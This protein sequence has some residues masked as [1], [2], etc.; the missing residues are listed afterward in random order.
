MKSSFDGRSFRRYS[1]RETG[2]FSGGG[3][4]VEDRYG[5]WI[6]NM[7][8][9]VSLFRNNKWRYWTFPA[10]WRLAIEPSTDEI[11]LIQ[12]DGGLFR[13]DTSTMDWLK[14]GQAPSVSENCAYSYFYL[15][16]QKLHLL[17]FVRRNYKWDPITAFTT[18]S[19]INASWT[20][21]KSLCETQLDWFH[22][23]T[24]TYQFL[25]LQDKLPPLKYEA[26]HQSFFSTHDGLMLVDAS[27]NSSGKYDINIYALAEEMPLRHHASTQSP[28][29]NNWL[30]I[31]KSGAIWLSAQAGL[32]RIDPAIHT[33]LTSDDN[34]IASLHTINEDD[35]GRI[36]F[37]GYETGLCYFENGKIHPPPPE[38][39]RYK[40][41]LPGNY[42]DPHG[43]MAFWT[44]DFW[45]VMYENGKWKNR[46]STGALNRE[47]GYIF[48]PLKE[49][50]IAA[51]FQGDGLGITDSPLTLKSKW[52]FISKEKGMLLD[53]VLCIAEDV[54]G[55]LWVG[56][57]SQGFAA[58]DPQTDTART[59]LLD[60]STVYNYGVGS[61]VLDRAGR[62]WM[63]CNDGIRVLER[64]H[65]LDIFNDNLDAHTIKIIMP[66]AGYSVVSSIT[67]FDNQIVFGNTNGF[68]VIDNSLSNPI[69]ETPQ[70]FF[71][72]TEHC[73]GP[74]DQNTFFPD[75][76]GYLWLGLENGAIRIDVEKLQRDT[77]PIK[78]IIDSILASSEKINLKSKLDSTGLTASRSLPSLKRYF[79]IFLKPSFTGFL[80]NNVG[81][82]Y[83]LLH[84][85]IQDTTWS[86]FEKTN[87]IIFRYLPPG[88]NRIEIRAIKNNQIADETFIELHVPLALSESPA[89]WIGSVGTL[90]LVGCL[91]GFLIY[92]Q[93]LQLKQ[94]QIDL[95][96]QRREKEQFQIRAIANSL[97]PHFIKNSLNWAQ[98]R[99]RSDHKV[100]TV[101]DELS[102]NISTIFKR[103]REGQAFH[104]LK[105]EFEL[106]RNYISIQQATYGHYIDISLP[107]GETIERY[108]SIVVPLM[109]IQI[110][111]ENAI[112]HGIRNRTGAHIL[113]IEITEGQHYLDL[114]ITD[115][116]IG[117]KGAVKLGSHGTQQGTLMLE[118]LHKIYNH[119]N[120]FKFSCHYEDLPLT[121][122]A[123]GEKTGTRIHI[124]IPKQYNFLI[125]ENNQVLY[126]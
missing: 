47:V 10:V 67:E 99:F 89:F 124:I 41:F 65:E 101:I 23:G 22:L 82:K 104:S 116:G 79:E 81:F 43:S 45:L 11:I 84:N 13:F 30:A 48:Q 92:R 24:A 113:I 72:S 69:S 63:G 90:C 119:Y 59:W 50:K 75:S 121:D 74:V 97:N 86:E 57:T 37:G 61:M 7:N 80:N 123:T 15:P 33:C 73:G 83:R 112:E 117:R 66:E 106:V 16:S 93:R 3:M 28:N 70:I 14:V 42:K 103:S 107:A 76:K 68:G 108:K 52:K 35:Q 32:T 58:Y 39:E 20:E 2:H 60:P 120:E 55:K 122:P 12:D 114:T 54:A 110:H 105:D 98:T 91:I 8:S 5:L 53:N 118:S 4:F 25:N 126:S 49:G 111:V 46:R 6:C 78:I 36:W 102:S 64:P 115:D 96:E 85:K 19:L 87:K 109:Q 40:R 95:S 100:A 56:R 94:V 71:Y 31:D 18:P 125:H 38:V 1:P 29:R 17:Q 9:S 51:G 88:S 21:D 44:E 62:L 34:M 26:S 77:L 27:P